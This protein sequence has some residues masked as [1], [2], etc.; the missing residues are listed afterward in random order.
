MNMPPALALAAPAPEAKPPATPAAKTEPEKADPNKLSVT[1]HEMTVDGKTL[2]YRATAGR[3]GVHDEA[4]KPKADF[5][6]VAYERLPAQTDPAKRPI[7]F[8]FNGGPGAA[9]V[10]LHLG[11]VGP[12]RLAIDKDTDLPASPV[13]LEDNSDSWLT[14]TD[15]VFIDPVGTGYSRA[16]KDEN[17]AQFFGVHEDIRWV[18][19]F[20]RLYTTQNQRWLS[21]KY[22]AGESYGT[23]RAA[24]LS[25]YL[26]KA[27]GI[28]LSGIIL[29]SSVLN[30]ATIE[31]GPGNDLPYALYLPSYT[32]AAWHHHKLAPDLQA[33]LPKAIAKARQWATDAYGPAL[34][35][36][37]A[38]TADERTAICKNLARF[39][40]LAPEFA[41]KANLRISPDRFEGSLLAAER[42]VIGRFDAR[43]TGFKPD[44]L[45]PSAGADPSFQPYLSAY[46]AA[47]NDYLRRGLKYE[48][49][50]PY[51]VLSHKTGPWDMGEGGH[52]YLDVSE[53][54]AD[55]MTANPRL[56]VM[57]A[58]GYQDLATPFDASTYAIDHMNLS[59]E[60][61]AQISHRFYE[62]GHMFY[63]H[64]PSLAPFGADVRAFIEGEAVQGKK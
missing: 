61:R 35:R 41:D 19:E 22:L 33:D 58:S 4:G 21:P 25:Q 28:D 3:M 46:S 42:K 31:A 53:N 59:P 30:F 37:A 23:T 60:S 20:I 34:A 44:P 10:W 18:A 9:A 40:G 7:T 38:L 27:D 45:N 5:F 32:A 36:G 8:V 57:F 49:D 2:K 51:E 52:G 50:L 54:L 39:T 16:A 47:I 63:H 24:G 48:N 55:A 6:F 64:R 12:Q 14:A 62:G 43:L 29:I 17:P 56:R 11:A 26:Q 1:E 15:L 13:H